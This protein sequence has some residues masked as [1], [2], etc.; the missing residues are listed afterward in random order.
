MS[1][2]LIKLYKN[3]V[4]SITTC[5]KNSYEKV[6]FKVVFVALFFQERLDFELL[7]I[8]PSLAFAK[9]KICLLLS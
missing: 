7:I 8:S 3:N 1:M 9:D 5:H 2:S 6:C 4:I